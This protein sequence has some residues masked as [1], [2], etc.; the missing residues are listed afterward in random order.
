MCHTARA[1]AELAPAAAA[2]PQLVEVRVERLRQCGAETPTIGFRLPCLGVH[3]YVCRPS[4]ES[5]KSGDMFYPRGRYATT[6]PP[7]P[8]VPVTANTDPPAIATPPHD[9]APSGS[10][11]S[12]TPVPA[13]R[14]VRCVDMSVLYTTPFATLTGLKW[15]GPPSLETHAAAPAWSSA[16]ISP[17]GVSGP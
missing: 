10:F 12:T 8:C 2:G 7:E 1:V 9:G 3:V 15:S 4:R 5:L 16:Q 11:A 13:S 17:A 6:Y 14:A